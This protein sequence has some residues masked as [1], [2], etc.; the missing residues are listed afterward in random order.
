MRTPENNTVARVD[1]SWKGTT[2]LTYDFPKTA[3]QG[4]SGQWKGWSS[5]FRKL[6]LCADPE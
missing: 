3:H 2:E 1:N 4:V 5:E 6:N